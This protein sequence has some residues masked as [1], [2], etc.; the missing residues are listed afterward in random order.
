MNVLKNRFLKRAIAF[1]MTAV[2]TVSVSV[3]AFAEDGTGTQWTRLTR[4]EQPKVSYEFAQDELGVV[5]FAPEWGNKEANIESM[6]SYVEEA[7]EKG[8]KILLFPEM[9]VTGYAYSNDPDSEVYQMAVQNAEPLDGPT[10]Q[11]FAELSDEYDMWIIYGAT[12]TVEGDTEHAYNSAFACSPDGEVTA[13]QKITP[14]EGDW[15]TPGETPVL[16]DTE[17]GLIG[18]SICYDTYATPELERYYAALGCNIL[19]NPTATSRSYGD[20]DGDG[21]VEDEGWEW[22][23]KDRLE[24]IASRDGM[25]ILSANLEGYDGPEDDYNFPGGSVII[26]GA[27]NGPKYY[28]G[29]EDADGTI[30]TDADIITGEEGLLTNSTELTAST[31]STCRNQDFNP[32]LY[33]ELY[34]ELAEKQ[35]N[36]E[37]LSYYSDVTDGPKAAV[38]N[39]PGIWGDKEANKEAMIEYIKEA[40]EQ[41]V[42]ILVFPETVLTGYEWKQP[43]DDPF[44]AEYGVAMQVALAETIPG[45]TTNELSEYA[46][47]YGMYIIFGMTEK[48]ETPIY[49]EGVEKVYNAAAILYPDGSID[50]YRKI[51]RAG[52]E[53][54]WS[55][56]GD[57]PYIIDTEWGKAGIDICRDGH[58]YPEL[59]RYYAASGC[60]LF[61]H[62]TAT[63][64]NP[65]YRETRI[66]S[67]TDRDGMAAITCNL[68]GG[69]GTYIGPQVTRAADSIPDITD[70]EYWKQENWTGGVFNSTSLIITK[71]HDPETGRTGVNPET[72]YA[73]DLNGT[74]SESEGFAERGTSPMG[75]EI[76]DMDLSGCGFRI[77]N[78]NAALFSKMYDKLAL[79]YREGY[80]SLYGENAVADYVS[81]KLT[82]TPQEPEVPQEPET[83]Q[84]PEVPQEPETPQESETP[85]AAEPVQQVTQPEKESQ[86]VT[87]AVEPKSENVVQQAP[88]TGDTAGVAMLAVI[89]A[90]AG[91]AAVVTNSR[92]R[93]ER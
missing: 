51:H 28:A 19:L 92:V 45:D 43:E 46:K 86:S 39:M 47:Q 63:T 93:K 30:N 2:M 54:M 18:L 15:C 55:V 36:G 27:F 35:A 62:P 32:E 9:C 16:L 75:L 41:G 31:G 1:S 88:A 82:E 59:G 57:E 89:M 58:F 40:G 53:V 66:G 77:V 87:A 90:A 80:E 83:P 65:W 26:Q 22:Y 42:D 21:E 3:M 29:A 60:T 71:Y 74:G 5:N 52:Y 7:H 48:E 14:V 33:A 25:T 44:Y 56:C 70:E 64:G 20:I 49:D 23:Y 72:G 67:Y 68:L 61:I 38:V 81:K 37:E 12:Q 13:Y 17:Y 85:Q 4:K 73:I 8:V 91:F 78:F 24:S 50:S 69:D 79:L 76:A 84:N 6:I 11:E 34:A 10:A